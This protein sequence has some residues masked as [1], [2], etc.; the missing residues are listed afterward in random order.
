MVLETAALPVEPKLT[1]WAPSNFEIIFPPRYV[2]TVWHL[3][4]CKNIIKKSEL[5]FLGIYRYLGGFQRLECGF[6]YGV[7]INIH[8]LES[9]HSILSG[10][11]AALLVGV[12]HVLA[13]NLAGKGHRS[14]L[15]VVMWPWGLER[16]PCSKENPRNRKI[17]QNQ[18]A[19]LLF[20]FGGFWMLYEAG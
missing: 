15:S 1:F 12:P 14:I 20:L 11:S 17:M 6:F 8:H 16:S 4:W 10:F 5:T 13:G 2:R 9:L 19:Y 3:E 7:D 18:N